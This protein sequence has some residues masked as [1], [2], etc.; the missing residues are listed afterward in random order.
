MRPVFSV[1]LIALSCATASASPERVRELLSELETKQGR[2][3]SRTQLMMMTDDPSI[4]L[5]DIESVA[6]SMQDLSPN[7][8]IYLKQGALAR[9]RSKQRKGGLGVSFGTARLGHVEIQTIVGT[10][11]FPAAAMLKPGDV[12]VEVAGKIV[13]GSEHF[14]AEILSRRPGDLLP[15]ILQRDEMLI[16]RD[17]PLGAYSN[18]TGASNIESSVL[19]HAL[20]LRWDRLEIEF[21]IHDTLGNGIDSKDWIAAAFPDG[22]AATTGPVDESVDIGILIAG[23]GRLIYAGY[24]L[25]PRR[26]K[27]WSSEGIAQQ[28]VL[29]TQRMEISAQISEGFARRSQLIA[30]IESVRAIGEQDGTLE[31]LGPEIKILR[32]QQASTEITIQ[33]LTRQLDGLKATPKPVEIPQPPV[34]PEED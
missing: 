11:A 32:K 18:L 1:I 20:T 9:F 30:R 19:R 14:R 34:A 27:V 17:L 6:V 31:Q 15:V 25:Y 2:D 21:P 26:G 10:D 28:A 3:L 13:K 22:P 23:R 33:R 5:E 29:E 16:S 12:V 24:P 8:L 4:T 7:Q